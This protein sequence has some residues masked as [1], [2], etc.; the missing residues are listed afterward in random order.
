MLITE[1]T[2]RAAWSY[3]F[4]MGTSYIPLAT[5]MIK[6]TLGTPRIQCWHITTP[7]GFRKLKTIEGKNAQISCFTQIEDLAGQMNGIET[8]GGVLV[9]LSADE[10]LNTSFD[11]YSSVDLKGI[12][13]VPTDEM[14]GELNTAVTKLKE[15]VVHK[16]IQNKANINAWIDKYDVKIHDDVRKGLIT[17]FLDLYNKVLQNHWM[18]FFPECNEE[19]IA[20]A[21]KAFNEGVEKIILK[22]KKVIIDSRNSYSGSNYNEVIANRIEV[23][24]V[25]VMKDKQK[26]FEEIN[27]EQEYVKVDSKTLKLIK[28]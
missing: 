18:E 28:I 23:L 27:Q 20:K 25:Y 14:H 5:S 9:K 11:S 1:A 17:N 24:K 26:E 8:A 22:Y 15:T 4:N 12:R 21:L 7:D 2:R 3:A 13:W 10:I 19:D 16:Y 6:R